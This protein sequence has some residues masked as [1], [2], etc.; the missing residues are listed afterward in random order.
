VPVGELHPAAMTMTIA[1]LA[2]IG[3]TLLMDNG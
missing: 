2:E 3:P 1:S